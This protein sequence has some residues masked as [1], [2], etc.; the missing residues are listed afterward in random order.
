M[1]YRKLKADSIFNG[2]QLLTEK[3]LVLSTEGIIQDIVP[4]AEAGDDVEEV[5]GIL[6]PG[7]INCHCHLELS[8]L[9]D[10]IPPHTG[11]VP[12]LVSVVSKR[13]AA[14]DFKQ[15]AIH[16]AAEEMWQKGIA[17]VGDICNTADALLVKKESKIRWH[18]FV[19]V[20]NFTD[21]ALAVELLQYLTVRQK[22]NEAGL[23]AVLTP[24]APYTISTATYK[25][26][27]EATAGQII[28]MH[29]Q[30]TVSE[31]E[32]FQTGGGEFLNLF[33]HFGKQASPFAISGV[34]SLQTWLPHFTHGQTILLVHN[35]FLSEE[36]VVFAKEH[37]ARYGLTLVYCL[38]VNA[39]LY[40]ENKLP[41]VEMLMKNNC[42]IVLGTDS[43][44]SNWQLSIASEIQTIRKHFPTIPLETILTWATHNGAKAM[45]W[46]DLG[47]FEKGKKPGVVQWTDTGKAQRLI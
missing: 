31:N 2:Q 47:S 41:P 19:E 39:N 28:S 23:P 15:Q 12:F 43:Y 3:V 1:Q 25:A 27:N 5:E 18:S 33:G 17:G 21:E 34:T 20:L 13:G 40:I 16:R 7:F 11:L 45:Q 9:K 36:D 38:C 46:N 22:Y 30:E 10:V 24:H 14:E 26:I 44:S 6:L 4:A 37:A 8:H 32:L 29:N 42:H 35:T